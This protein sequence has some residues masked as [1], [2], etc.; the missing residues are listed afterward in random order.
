MKLGL[1]TIQKTFKACYTF[2]FG[3]NIHSIKIVGVGDKL[4]E[5]GKIVSKIVAATTGSAGLAKGGV[6]LAE[7]IACQD[8]ICAFVS[9]I[10]CAADPAFIV[11]IHAVVH[12]AVSHGW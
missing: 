1:K 7:A 3:V 6:D 5:G 9:G 4:S 2:V 8:G 10:G 12:P 11:Q